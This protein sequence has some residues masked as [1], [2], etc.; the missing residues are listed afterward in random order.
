MAALD[1]DFDRLNF[2]RSDLG[3]RGRFLDALSERLDNEDVELRQ[4]L[5]QEIDVDMVDVISD[6]AARQANLEAT[7]RLIGR[8]MQL[9]LLNFL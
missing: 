2:A 9:T 7:L 6:L 3:A 5:S 4:A 1:D 8:T